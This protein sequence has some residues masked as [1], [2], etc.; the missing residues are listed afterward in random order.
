MPAREGHLTGPWVA[1]FLRAFDEQ[2]LW[3]IKGFAHDDRNR[4]LSCGRLGRHE[5]RIV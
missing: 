5:I 2:Y 1:L 3:A 4:R